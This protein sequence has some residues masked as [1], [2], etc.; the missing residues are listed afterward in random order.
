MAMRVELVE[1]DMGYRHYDVHDGRRT[2]RA[3]H[4]VVKDEWAVFNS[5]GQILPDNSQKSFSIVQ[6]CEKWFNENEAAEAG[7]L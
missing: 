6:A 7:A 5:R 3:V 2:Y 1:R 4:N